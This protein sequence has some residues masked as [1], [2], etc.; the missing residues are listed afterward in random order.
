MTTTNSD[1]FTALLRSADG[2]YR[3][4]GIYDNQ[5]T[6]TLSLLAIAHGLAALRPPADAPSS[7]AV[8]IAARTAVVRGELARADAQAGTALGWTGTAAAVVL[9][10]SAIGARGLSVSAHITLWTGAALVAGAVWVL[11]SAVS[12][13]IPRRGGVGFVL[14]AEDTPEELL[15][16]LSAPVE[17]TDRDA[18]VELIYLSRLAK[19][20]F[21]RIRLANRL[22]RLALPLLVATLPLNLI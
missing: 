5:K 2:A 9:A 1:R 4:E 21:Y 18:A 15:A 3:P 16:R 13:T 12:P 11:L 22:M 20:K 7:P 8:A 10:L 6:R 17:Q 19:R 14:D